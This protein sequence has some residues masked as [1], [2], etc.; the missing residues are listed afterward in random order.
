MILRA[1][2]FC[3][4]LLMLGG[5]AGGPQETGQAGPSGVPASTA[6][7]QP[8]SLIGLDRAGLTSTLGE[9]RMLRR[10]APAEIWQYRSRSCVLDVFLYETP[11]GIE[12]V[13]HLEAR[14]NLAEA[15][16]MDRCMG[17]V[18]RRT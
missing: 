9:P 16:A 14:N 3:L 7:K 17:S 13:T 11:G 6:H 2:G 5:C 15:V 4:L 12:T 18:L 1:L 8:E 10:E